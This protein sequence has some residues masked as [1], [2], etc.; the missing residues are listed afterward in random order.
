MSYSAKPGQRVK[1][2]ISKAD[3]GAAAFKDDAQ[4]VRANF[5]QSQSGSFVMSNDAVQ[6]KLEIWNWSGGWYGARFALFIDNKN[7]DN[8]IVDEGP[9]IPA[10]IAWSKVFVIEPR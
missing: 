6:I 4:F 9:A 3:D 1:V 8:F 10:P 2:V 7:V 5:Q